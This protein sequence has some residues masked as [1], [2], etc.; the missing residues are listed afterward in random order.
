LSLSLISES[1][2][3]EERIRSNFYRKKKKKKEK[4]N[5]K[6]GNENKKTNKTEKH[7]N[8]AK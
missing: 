4:E 8:K 3:L 6:S 1:L 7:P 5:H 2:G